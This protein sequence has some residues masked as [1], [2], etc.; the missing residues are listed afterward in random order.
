[1]YYSAK[2]LSFSFGYDNL[3]PY[4]TGKTK[5]LVQMRNIKG[6]FRI[7]Y[8]NIFYQINIRD[9]YGYS[10]YGLKMLAES[11]GLSKFDTLDS[12]KENM[13]KALIEK[14]DDF[15]KYSIN[16][17]ELLIDIYERK[18]ESFN[19][20]LAIFE[21]TD[22]NYLFTKKNTPSTIGSVV[23]QIF[24]K[25]LQIKVFKNDLIYL[26]CLKQGILNNMH[27]DYTE[28]LLY[29]NKLKEIK[30]L[31]NF[32]KYAEENTYE[33]KLMKNNL[34]RSRV[35]NYHAFKAIC[36]CKLFNFRIS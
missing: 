13:D 2:D 29:Y 28:N 14:T 21:I 35:F 24:R 34:I 10:Q 19:Q 30:N 27:N 9:L 8:D 15:I 6:N 11:V 16:D 5:G 12:Y 7:D 25:Y 20:L 17:A 4:Y 1:M 31:D 3:K 33:F 23:H 22:E 18:I 36:I 32:K 26:S